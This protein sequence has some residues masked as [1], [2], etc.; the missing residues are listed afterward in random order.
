MINVVVEMGRLTAEPE[1]R[2]TKGEEPKSVCTFTLAVNENEK[3]NFFDV[4]SW[5]KTAE[6]LAKYMHKGDK[7][8][9]LGKLG[10]HS[11]INKDGNLRRKI[12]IIANRIVFAESNL[13]LDQPD[14]DKLN[15]ENYSMD[16]WRLIADQMNR[17]IT[18][19][20]DDDLPF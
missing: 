2:K 12:E 1:L 19:D 5:G 16:E 13:K 9:V 15:P 18:E 17:E 11:W 7:I 10:T 20:P 6:A 3:V 8:I 14:K 4:I